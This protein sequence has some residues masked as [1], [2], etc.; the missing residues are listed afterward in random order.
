[1][2]L[3]T[4]EEADRLITLHG[5]NPAIKA[6]WKFR[7]SIPDEYYQTDYKPKPKIRR[8]EIGAT[9]QIRQDRL[10]IVF[11]NPKW[12]IK[13]IGEL[14]GMPESVLEAFSAG[15]TK[16][17]EPERTRLT[18][19]IQ[20]ARTEIKNAIGEETTYSYPRMRRLFAI[21]SDNR[22]KKNV[23]F[24]N[25]NLSVKLTPSSLKKGMTFERLSR[26]EYEE[27]VSG[28]SLLLLETNL[29]IESK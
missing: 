11:S 25:V 13:R 17:T 29:Y 15:K 6:K 14:A 19:V 3:Y 8:N 7:K 12:Y 20:Q 27:I 18:N 1:M 26:S 4:N 5:L 9:E 2:A 16:L 24:P 22:L 21:A 28:L 10:Q 23:V